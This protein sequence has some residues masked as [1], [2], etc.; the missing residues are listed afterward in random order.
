MGED[1]IRTR[2][3]VSVS[4]LDIEGSVDGRIVLAPGIRGSD[5]TVEL[6]GPDL[7]ELVREFATVEGIP[8]QPYDVAGGLRFDGENLRFSDVLGEVGSSSVRAD[9]EVRIDQG[10]A[11]LRV[12]FDLAGP[13]LEDLVADLGAIELQPGPYELSSELHL[14]SERI[15]F[16]DIEY[17]RPFGEVRGS[18]GMALNASG[19]EMTF[20]LTARGDD[21]H[22]VLGKVYG[23]EAEEMAFAFDVRGGLRETLISLDKLDITVGAAT[24]NAR[25]ELDFGEARRS[26]RFALDVNVPNLAQLGSLNGLRLRE[27]GFALYADIRGD[28]EKIVVENLSAKIDESDVQGLISL[29][30]GDVPFLNIDVRSDSLRIAPLLEERELEYDPEPRAEGE[31]LIADIPVPFDDMRRLNARINVRIGDFRRD[32][33]RMTDLVVDGELLDGGVYLHRFGFNAPSGW[34]EAKGSL[35]PVDA[36]GAGSLAIKARDFALGISD[37]NPD[38]A[39][40]GNLD[41]NLES[42]GTDLR[43]LVGNAS[44][45]AYATAANLTI[46]TSSTLRRIYGDMLNE[47]LSAINPFS[48]EATD[49][50]M[51][52]IVIPLEFVDGKLLTQP[53][54]VA[55]APR[56]LI[57]VTADVNLKSGKLDMN[58]RNTPRRGITLSAG[59]LFNPYVKVVGTISRPRL[60]VDEQGVLISGGAAVATGGLSILAKA[61]WSRLSQPRD[62]CGE[63]MEESTE[64]LGSRFP[65]LAP[66]AN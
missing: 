61:A 44:G 51:E 32:R 56:F 29:E 14:D 38:L 15:R 62:P 23:F 39:A 28:T 49:Q 34:L 12:D 22:Q 65:D 40:T 33:L 24:A 30:K 13:A 50:K 5:F 18:F 45:V 43:S 41:I 54:V 8:A 53:Y 4:S 20:D 6:G 52:C 19:R 59:E 21:L 55:L 31:R 10:F 37:F 47:I 1:S 63:L 48:R 25:G 36:N 60:A 26:T 46:A 66:P 2:G 9:G 7:A 11:G 17:S 57:G 27:Q 64:R 16:D 3:P 58:F 42:T 35:R